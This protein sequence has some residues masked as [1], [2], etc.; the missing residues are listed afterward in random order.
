MHVKVCSQ[1]NV[2]KCQLCGPD[3]ARASLV[4]GK[5]R[6]WN[7]AGQKQKDLEQ[8]VIQRELVRHSMLV[9][10][11]KMKKTEMCCKYLP[12]SQYFALIEMLCE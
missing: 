11:R 7:S 4:S 1:K 5:S 9:N 2:I 10:M 6:N 3:C 12:K 8:T